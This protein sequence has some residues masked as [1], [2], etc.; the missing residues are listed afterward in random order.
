MSISDEGAISPETSAVNS[1]N[2][3]ALALARLADAHPRQ[4]AMDALDIAAVLMRSGRDYMAGEAA[5]EA[6]D[7]DFKEF[8][9]SMCQSLDAK[10]AILR[11][12][13]LSDIPLEG[14]DVSPASSQQP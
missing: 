3:L 11:R 10:L 4:H 2:V 5:S 9:R 6:T 7:R 1:S 8:A 12:S 14:R 13:R